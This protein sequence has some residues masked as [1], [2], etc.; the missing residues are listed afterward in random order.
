MD[1]D[2]SLPT[3]SK[4]GLGTWAG[5][6]PGPPP[7]QRLALRVLELR[8]VRAACMPT[9][10]ER[11]PLGPASAATNRHV[12]SR[13]G[14]ER[15]AAVRPGS[16]ERVLEP[17][18]RSSVGSHATVP[19]VLRGGASTRNHRPACHI[20]GTSRDGARG[21][22]STT[23]GLDGC[24]SRRPGQASAPHATV[25]LGSSTRRVARSAPSLAAWSSPSDV[26]P[27]AAHVRPSRQPAPSE[28][29]SSGP[30]SSAP[31]PCAFLLNPGRLRA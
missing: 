13:T 25:P 15:T 22:C 4:H 23:R 6:R 1:G 27:S 30:T 14:G 7:G 12:G 3:T 18:D 8:P 19:L 31:P 5:R 9:P 20:E 24:W 26:G 28:R 10:S 11:A 17:P 2:P 16:L 29:T 21:L